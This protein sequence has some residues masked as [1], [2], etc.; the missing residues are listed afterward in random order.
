MARKRSSKIGGQA[1]MEG[2]MMRGE[3]S[4]AT[5]VRTP[6]GN[7]VVESKRLSAKTPW[8]RKVPILRGAVNF[9][10]M[11]F[12]G[13]GILM[14]SAEV[15]GE[16]EP[17]DFE[18]KVAK[19]FKVSLFDVAIWVGVILGIA[20]SVFLFVMLPQFIL[21]GLEWLFSW[22]PSPFV[23]N[24][25]MGL[26]RMLIFLLYILL[27]S[28]MKDVKR[29]YMYHGAEHKTIACY[30]ADMP[31]TVENVRG[32][33]KEHDR[34][35]TTFM[36]IVMAISIIFFSLLGLLGLDGDMWMRIG[37]RL[38]LMPVVAGISYEILKGLAKFDNFFVRILKAP[39]LFLQKFTTRQPDDGMIEVAIKAFQ[40]AQE[41]DA[42]ESIEPVSFNIDK[43]FT[44]ALT[45]IHNKLRKNKNCNFEADA[46]WIV[47]SV[48]GITRSEVKLLKTIKEED[49]K[50]ITSL[51][52][53]RANGEP[54][55]YVLGEQDFCNVNVKCDK[56]AL[57]PRFETEFMVDLVIKEIGEAKSVLDM[58]TGSGAIAVAI[59][60]SCPS[61]KV[62]AV[63]KYTDALSLARENAD[64]NEVEIEFVQS[65]MFDEVHSCFDVIVSNP[66]YITAKD[67]KK[68]SPEV[69]S[70]PETAL[71]GG[72]DGLDFYRVLA[73]KAKD[74]LSQE[75]RLYL[76]VG[77]GQAESVAAL[78]KEDYQNT[79]I[80]KDLD[81]V[82]RIVYAENK[83]G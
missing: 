30:E 42:D 56:R 51:V 50:K 80:I 76:E 27:T 37:L 14:R 65:D 8:W 72:E 20:M 26:I 4:V 46:E 49:L 70:E 3:R 62:T 71:F 68:L 64:K 19:K 43:N 41:M 59:K 53:R 82:E 66:P 21:S 55:Q 69:K 29:V 22:S 83:K 33:T 54:L 31:L 9:F 58:C 32:C 7:I 11:L 25:I 45:D 52:D 5:A 13:M 28:L 77:K 2:V 78:L 75:G 24:L 74:F 15:Y 12:E 6:D 40:T 67:M 17:S 48:L 44:L 61:V 18:K 57:I 81:G 36:F 34:C 73:S 39:G 23:K 47:S 38:V 10:L 35:G 16:E 60:K 79:L 1:V 63:D